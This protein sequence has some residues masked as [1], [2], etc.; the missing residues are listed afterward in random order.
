MGVGELPEIAD[1]NR[2]GGLVAGIPGN[3]SVKRSAYFVGTSLQKL[4]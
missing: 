4:L 2:V 1:I 3:L